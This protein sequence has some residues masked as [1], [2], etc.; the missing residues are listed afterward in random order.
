MV[1][2]RTEQII[3]AAKQAYT[4]V[5]VDY[6]G[7]VRAGAAINKLILDKVNLANDQETKLMDYEQ[8]DF[9]GINK[10]IL[11]D[12]NTAFLT[13][14]RNQMA[15]DSRI[16]KNTLSI[17][18]KHKQASKRWNDSLKLLQQLKT[19]A[20]TFTDFVKKARENKEFLSDY[21]NSADASFIT[22]VIV[23]PEPILDSVQ[24]TQ[25]GI[26]I[27]GAD[28]NM[29]SMEDLPSGVSTQDGSEIDTAIQDSINNIEQYTLNGMYDQN[30]KDKVL[31]D[32]QKMI[33]GQKSNSIGSAIFDYEYSTSD[34]I[35]SYIDVL[36]DQNADL[37]QAYENVIEE[38]MSTDDP[39]DTELEKE[40]L[41][42][43]LIREQPS[44]NLEKM[45][46]D[47][48]TWVNDEVFS[49]AASV[50]SSTVKSKIRAN[51]D[52][53][54][55]SKKEIE[56]L[57]TT[58]ALDLDSGNYTTVT[59][60]R[61]LPVQGGD[62]VISGT[63]LEQMLGANEDWAFDNTAFSDGETEFRLTSDGVLKYAEEIDIDGEKSYKWVD[64]PFQKNSASN[65][66]REKYNKIVEVI[67]GLSASEFELADRFLPFNSDEVFYKGRG[68]DDKDFEDR[69]YTEKITHTRGNLKG[70]G[71]KKNWFWYENDQDSI[72]D[73][74]EWISSMGFMI[75]RRTKHIPGQFTIY[76]D[77]DYKNSFVLYTPDGDKIR[78]R[79]FVKKSTA[80]G[81]AVE[82]DEFINLWYRRQVKNTE[83]EYK[84][85]DIEDVNNEG[86]YVGQ[87]LL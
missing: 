30:K 54:V 11:N 20:T 87:G 64:S 25:Q 83:K 45:K 86:Q 22:S 5:K 26:K 65:D 19:D 12:A 29:V 79:T 34:G 35:V 42:K 28:G 50:A 72:P 9:A 6:S 61:K 78:L 41:R 32:F 1:K 33:K 52:N 58:S 56:N 13:D 75:E 15:E 73:I 27:M 8:E 82:L 76:N 53:R 36:F 66:S 16:M 49:N 7:Y 60:N 24:F 44:F 48:I 10:T 38:S 55:L 31:H 37:K 84:Y 74:V 14:L 68:E 59:S 18:K 46:D 63:K 47:F 21:Q 77:S 2:I 62:M 23:H 3:E 39:I 43:R 51:R 80:K 70:K 69:V 67:N 17:T 71:A 81:N 85:T 4:P 57:K 40:K